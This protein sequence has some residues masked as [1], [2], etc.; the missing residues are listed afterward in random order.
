MNAEMRTREWTVAEVAKMID[1]SLLRP[2]LTLDDV[3]EGCLLAAKYKV[4]TVCVKPCDVK[5]AAGL[6]HGSGVLVS[7]VAAFPHGS[8]TTAVKVAETRAA[9]L[10]GAAEVDMVLNIGWL[11]SGLV[12]AVEEDIRAVV[13]ASGGATVKV[14]LENAYL[15]DEQIIAGCQA[16]ERAGAQFVKTST[17]FAPSGA[18]MAQLRLM[19]KSVSPHI[20]VKA[21]GGVR[22]IDVLLDM[23]SIGVTRFGATRTD[24][25]LDDLES[26]I[27]TGKP[28]TSTAD[29]G[30]GY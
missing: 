14:I 16:A 23:A 2:E 30:G 8:S 22:T 21:A 24:S 19:R 5:Y 20:Q 26:R 13:G 29:D 6:L 17:G 15:D 7:T 10:D 27:A 28:L 25:M 3:R 18:T 12:D 1:H 9:V 11:R 4:A